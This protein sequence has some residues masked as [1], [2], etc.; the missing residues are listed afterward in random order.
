MALAQGMTIGFENVAGMSGIKC[1]LASVHN[2][3]M[4][5]EDL[6]RELLGEGK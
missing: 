1:G 5:L 6:V 2:D 4:C 3:G